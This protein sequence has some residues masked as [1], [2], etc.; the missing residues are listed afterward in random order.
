MNSVQ[1]AIFPANFRVSARRVMPAP[2]PVQGTGDATRHTG[3]SGYPFWPLPAGGQELQAQVELARREPQMEQVL[4]PRNRLA[5]AAY[6]TL[7]NGSERERLSTLL[8]I[9]EYA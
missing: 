1:S 6:R 4:E 9:D 2:E 3:A 8:G 5:I 7:E